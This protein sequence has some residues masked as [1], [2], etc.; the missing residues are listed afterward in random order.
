M[1]K[2]SLEQLDKHRQEG[3]RP[4]VVLCL[5]ANEKILMVFKKDHKL[6]QLPQGRINNKEDLEKA[7]PRVVEE[8][9]GKDF[10]N[11]VDYKTAQYVDL[12]QMEFKPGRHQLETLADDSGKEATMLGKVYYFAALQCKDEELDITKSQFDQHYWMSFREA[13]FLAERIY[14]RGKRRITMKVLN[15]LFSLELIQ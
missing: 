5:I 7:L 10:A 13:Y 3:F 14:Q 6:W 11:K 1:N 4:G 2:P 8:E 9:M 15:T 12:D